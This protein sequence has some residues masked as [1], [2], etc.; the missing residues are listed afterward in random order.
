MTHTEKRLRFEEQYLLIYCSSAK[1]HLET[2]LRPWPHDKS[3][4]EGHIFTD[5]QLSLRVV[6]LCQLHLTVLSFSRHSYPEL[7]TM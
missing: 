7:L 3:W 4:H 1:D 6:K 5:I 2:C